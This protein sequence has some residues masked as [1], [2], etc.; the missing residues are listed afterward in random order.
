VRNFRKVAV[1]ALLLSLFAAAGL[2]SNLV[3]ADASPA[4]RLQLPQL[5]RAMP[6]T[7]AASLVG[8]KRLSSLNGISSQRVF[9]SVQQD[10]SAWVDRSGQL[11]YVEPKP[12]AAEPAMATSASSTES[13]VA[14]IQ[15]SDAF[16]LQSRPGSNR[17]IYIDFLGDV[18]SN[19]DWNNTYGSQITAPAYDLD[20]DPSTFN[21]LERNNIISIWQRVSEDYAPFDV[22]VS[23]FDLGAD[24]IDRND[25][26]D[27]T[28]GTRALVT[29]MP[30]S[31]AEKCGCAG[32]A[33]L[34]TFDTSYR[35]LAQQPAWVFTQ[36]LSGGSNAKFVAEAVSHEVGHTFGLHHDGQVW[37]PAEYDEGHGL[38]APIMGAS[39][40]APLSQWS[41][42]EYDSA[43]NFEDDLA[44]IAQSAPLVSDDYANQISGA[45]QIAAGSSTTD[46]LI[47]YD[48]DVDVFRVTSATGTLKVSADPALVSPNLDIKLDLLD[49]NGVVLASGNPI[50]FAKSID[51]DTG[52]GGLS[53]SISKF[54]IAGTY[55]LRVDGVGN[56]NFFNYYSDYDSLGRYTLS[57]TIPEPNTPAT[58]LPTITRFSPGSAVA[59]DLVTVDGSNLA[60]ILS[61]NIG[62]QPAAV[63]VVSDNRI[64]LRV[65]NQAATGLISLTNSLG[66]VQSGSELSVS[67]PALSV[68]GQPLLG[69]RFSLSTTAFSSQLTP[70]F[71]WLRD[72]NPIGSATR[73]TYTATSSDVG[74]LISAEATLVAEDGFS[75]KVTSQ[76]LGPVQGGQLQILSASISGKA[77]VG[78]VLKLNIRTSQPD[79][80]VSF[81]WMRNGVPIANAQSSSYRLAKTD[82]AKTISVKVTA[83]AN[84]F[85]SA[86]RTLKL[87][88]KVG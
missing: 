5:S 52:I 18:V 59:G 48:Q 74:H 7:D 62:D 17:T 6:F 10:P 53:A 63:T 77:K 85:V 66:T 78:S 11:F 1:S 43:N 2:N 68:Q 47:S 71:R 76:P 20:G 70:T 86:T 4:E 75:F 79:A 83:K 31:I 87:S 27:K 36:N 55:Y 73:S 29:S 8:E 51:K 44:I 80:K 61:A 39:Y 38:W 15:P 24:A 25:A 41:N 9:D 21:E 69:K 42:G 13:N 35:H 56:D 65:S 58:E 19:T 57:T 33:Y 84:F 12:N 16:N 45:T 67:Q 23:T 64:K 49:S 82:R 46:G 14:T 32:L 88:T 72:G 50:S 40:Y 54:V 3:A 22:N 60:T 34:N 26:S 81:L 28:F 37:P 30:D